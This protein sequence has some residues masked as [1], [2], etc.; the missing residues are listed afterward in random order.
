MSILGHAL[1]PARWRQFG[2]VWAQEGA[3]VA[4]SRSIEVLARARR[5]ASDL[6]QGTRAGRFARSALWRDLAQGGAFHAPGV[7]SGRR[8]VAL[9]GDLNLPQCR[10]YRVEQM[11]DLWAGAGVAYRYAHVGDVP[12]CLDLMQEASHLVL[13]RLARSEAVT[14][15]LYEARRLGLPVLYDIDDP[16]FSVAAYAGYRNMD[17]LPPRLARQFLDDAPLYLDVMNMADAVSVS[18]PG[19]ALE[20]G[21]LTRRPVLLRRN[22]ADAAT[23]AAGARAMAP[24]G[25]RGLCL[26]V[27][28]GSL[29]HEADL[30]VLWPALGA[31]LGRDPA[32]RL[33]LLG[34]FAPDMVPRDLRPQ[35]R[36][37]GFAD[38]AA[39]LGD[40]AQADLALVPLADDPF[41]ACKS[42]V[43]VIDAAAVG[44]PAI[45]SGI[46]DL[47]AHVEDGV[48]GLVVRDP[49]RWADAL[50][51]AAGRDLAAMGQAARHL[52]AA[53]FAPGFQAPVTCGGL[54]EW[55][56][57]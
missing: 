35:V 6:A 39:Y 8:A 45:V 32:R 51:D 25:G 41:N 29:G 18:T 46:G 21:R 17:R 11:G 48:S 16:L 33:L 20:A 47:A 31:F 28:S 49:G 26:A 36:A 54:A 9:I 43:R 5:G 52:H 7:I 4:L 23:L 56:A 2:Q 38:Y 53:R 44:V 37:R 13:Y 24:K 15:Y 10:K 57:A 1:R 19:L 22:F 12:R 50:E 3:A 42:G 40:L 27:A 14:M 55:I 30:E 34:R